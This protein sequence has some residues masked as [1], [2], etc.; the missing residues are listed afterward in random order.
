MDLSNEIGP[1]T[2]EESQAISERM[3]NSLDEVA[4]QEKFDTIE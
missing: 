4:K 2:A 1:I 3:L